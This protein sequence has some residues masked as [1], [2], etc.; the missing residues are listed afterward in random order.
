M[1]SVGCVNVYYY[2]PQNGL[3]ILFGPLTEVSRSTPLN[4]IKIKDLCYITLSIFLHLTVQNKFIFNL[5]RFENSINFPY[6]YIFM[7]E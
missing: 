5:V 1:K 4:D 3:Y 6:K 2:M 7:C